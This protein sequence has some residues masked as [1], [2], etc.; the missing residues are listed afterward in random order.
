MIMPEQN[1]YFIIIIILFYMPKLLFPRLE[2]EFPCMLKTLSRT[3]PITYMRDFTVDIRIKDVSSCK[4]EN[5][6]YI[7]FFIS[8]S[9]A[10]TVHLFASFVLLLDVLWAMEGLPIYYYS[11]RKKLHLG[12]RI[13]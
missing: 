10:S 8:L 5:I 11:V 9:K 2:L 12:L 3:H 4:K 6:H 13:H 1:L 7:I